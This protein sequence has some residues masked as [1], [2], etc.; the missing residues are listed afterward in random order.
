MSLIEGG[1]H[2]S[3]NMTTCK[4][5]GIGIFIIQPKVQPNPFCPSG[6]IRNQFEPL[7]RSILG[8]HAIPGMN[9]NASETLFS[10]IRQLL[11]DHL[12]CNLTVPN[13]ERN[14]SVSLRRFSEM[15]AHLF[16]RGKMVVKINIST[17]R[18][19]QYQD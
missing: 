10:E 8:D 19:E 18:R 5:T 7:L 17:T 4:T 15:A 11:I 13:P 14:R 9:E 16:K 6:S 1:G 3:R 2:F 12:F